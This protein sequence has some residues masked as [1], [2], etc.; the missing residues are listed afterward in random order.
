MTREWD[1][2]L[3][4]GEEQLDAEHQAFFGF[5]SELE[6]AVADG[7]G[8]DVLGEIVLR[9]LEYVQTH[10]AYE[11]RLLAEAG[12]QGLERHRTVHSEFSKRVLEL[13]RRVVTGDAL[14]L[15]RRALLFLRNWWVQHV[16]KV[17]GEYAVELEWVER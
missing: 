10:F 3:S 11:E 6:Q 16:Q 9:L 5:V 4:V 17:D 15:D 14:A 7:K 2:S 12:Y 13:R 8:G 1:E